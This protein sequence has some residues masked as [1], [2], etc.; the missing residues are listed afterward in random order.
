MNRRSI[1]T[2]NTP[3]TPMQRI[4]STR[5]D[6]SIE[7]GAPPAARAA[8][9]WQSGTTKDALADAHLSTE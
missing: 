3:N 1:I 8:H 6:H 7:H 4:G 2:I 5:S 9:R